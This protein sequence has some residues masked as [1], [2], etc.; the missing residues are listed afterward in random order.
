MP[1]ADVTGQVDAL[2][3]GRAFAD[4]SAWRKV[5]VA[6]SEAAEWLNDLL[7][8]ELSGL[9]PGESRRSLLL[10]PTGRIRADLTVAATGLG[11]VLIQD[12]SQPAPIDELLSPYV[13]SS[14]VA[15]ADVTDELALIA[16]PGTDQAPPV[17]RADVLRPSCL[18]VGLDV[19]AP[20]ERAAE[21]RQAL[22]GLLEAG[23]HALEAWRI[24]RGVARFGVDVGEA[25]LP[26]EAGLDGVVAYQKGCF[27]GQEAM[28]RVRNLGHPPFVVLAAGGD[29]PARAG[30]AVLAGDEP[31]GSVTSAVPLRNGRAATIVRIRWAA[32]EAELRTA[33]GTV[34]RPSGAASGAA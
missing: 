18:G 34:L 12:P 22:S 33:D 1:H 14:D 11:T 2:R 5:R 26:Q 20:A 23:P 8:A 4:L 19:L 24:E 10:S 15:L 29:G 31:V 7:S 25:S 28:A 9:A 6:G 32:R 30:E 21:I 17:P 27:L 13:L 16:V 3:E